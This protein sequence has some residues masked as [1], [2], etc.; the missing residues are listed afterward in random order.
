MFVENLSE[1]IEEPWQAV[2]GFAVSKIPAELLRRLPLEN[3]FSLI[4]EKI[5][6]GEVI[7]SFVDDYLKRY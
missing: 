1:M 6:V 2:E 5:L 3:S 7:L 4:K